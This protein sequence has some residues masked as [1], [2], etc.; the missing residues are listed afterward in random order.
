M[1]KKEMK[2]SSERGDSILCLILNGKSSKK[3][4]GKEMLSKI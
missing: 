3:E 1:Y 2:S 4:V